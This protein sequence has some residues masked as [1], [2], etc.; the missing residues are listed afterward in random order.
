MRLSALLL[1]ISFLTAC[2]G[3]SPKLGWNP[4]VWAGDARTKS[5]VRGSGDT[6]EILST[7]DE[8]FDSMICMQNDEIR[9]ALT[10]YQNVIK[11]CKQWEQ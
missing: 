1:A 2:S 4:E 7:G 5:I 11:K 6:I 10:A 9:K 8:R 3:E